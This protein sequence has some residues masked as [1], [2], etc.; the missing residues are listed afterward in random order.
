M[1]RRATPVDMPRIM[2]M[3]LRF[4][5]ETQYADK[6]EENPDAIIDIVD[7]LM[8][9][10]DRLLIVNEC[11]GTVNGML[12]AFAFVHPISGEKVASEAFWWTEPE[13]RGAGVRMMRR[14]EDWAR[15]IGAKKMMMIAPTKRVG[16]FYKAIGYQMVEITYQRSL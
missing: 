1:I 7:K 9:G 10:E 3:G 16:D 5:R 14:A 2:E 11:K 15:S 13:C 8:S 4:I 6:I 12:G